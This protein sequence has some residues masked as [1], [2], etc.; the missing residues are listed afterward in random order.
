MRLF[1]LIQMIELYIREDCHMYDL[2]DKL[3]QKVLVQW[4][5][6]DADLILGEPDFV[7]CVNFLQDRED[8]LE[9]KIIHY[10]IYGVLGLGLVILLI[11]LCKIRYN[12]NN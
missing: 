6:F 5:A 2:A 4:N 3:I 12:Q 7:P 1:P 8:D 10:V 9:N 11:I